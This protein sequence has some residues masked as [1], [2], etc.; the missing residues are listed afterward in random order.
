[1]P[2]PPLT[3]GKSTVSLFSSSNDVGCPVVYTHLP[4]PDAEAVAALL[5]DTEVVLVSIDGA[6]WH[7]DLSPWPAPKAFPRQPD[8]AGGADAY[9]KELTAMVPAIEAQ[10][11][12][13]PTSRSIVGYSLAGLFA[14][15][16]GWR[17][18]LFD[19]VASVS[20]SLWYDGLLEAL[21]ASAPLR[22]P[23]RAYF[24]LGDR[25]ALTKNPRLAAVEECTVA[26]QRLL[27]DLGVPT[28]LELNPGNHF[29]DVAERMA[30][31]IR[32][33]TQ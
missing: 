18:D 11:G 1:M 23:E 12:L 2:I 31:G 8:F 10:A 33:I 20:G 21:R 24:S 3:F 13:S 22:L 16:A 26:A 29:Q 19:R 5:D 27:R 28:V 14:L 17:T 7:A 15:Y 6:D 30:K 9:L 4:A 32:W 25:E